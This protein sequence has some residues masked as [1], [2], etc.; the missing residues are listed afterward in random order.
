T[1]MTVVG[2]IPHARSAACSVQPARRPSDQLTPIAR[3]RGERRSPTK[4]RWDTSWLGEAPK[5]SGSAVEEPGNQGLQRQ[6]PGWP[7]L[8]RRPNGLSE[9]ID[10][11]RPTERHWTS[12]RRVAV[13]FEAARGGHREVVRA[14]N[15]CWAA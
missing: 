2:S 1:K 9:R 8:A 7:T 13:A 5:C 15:R 6:A 14:R 12:S 3:A 10:A 11:V 4:T